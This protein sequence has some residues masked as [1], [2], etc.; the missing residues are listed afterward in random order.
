ME[1]TVCLIFWK[2]HKYLFQNKTCSLSY[3]KLVFAENEKLLSLHLLDFYLSISNCCGLWLTRQNMLY[4][5][6]KQENVTQAKLTF[7]ESDP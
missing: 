4:F 7:N 1:V 5:G 2:Y 6:S 3:F